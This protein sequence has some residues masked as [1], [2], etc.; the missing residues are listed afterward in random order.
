MHNVI[1]M[2]Y[3]SIHIF[4]STSHVCAE[5]INW[6]INISIEMGLLYLISTLF[7]C[8]NHLKR[9]L[10]C[11]LKWNYIIVNS[12]WLSKFDNLRARTFRQANGRKACVRSIDMFTRTPTHQ[13]ANCSRQYELLAIVHNS[14]T[15]ARYR[16]FAHM[17]NAKW[18]I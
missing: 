9:H 16:H 8:I 3:H 12:M 10:W 15:R 4:P 17:K 5:C 1:A 13:H 11:D 18:F 7:V 14:H 2:P 6:N